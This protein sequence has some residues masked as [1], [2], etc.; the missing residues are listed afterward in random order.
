LW[1]TRILQ[2]PRWNGC[3]IETGKEEKHLQLV[4]GD[5]DVSVEIPPIPPTNYCIS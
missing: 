3:W 4:I 5:R 2:W 1:A